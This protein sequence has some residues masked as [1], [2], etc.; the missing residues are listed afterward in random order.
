MNTLSE[1]Y[2]GNIFSQSVILLFFFSFMISTFCVIAKK[3]SFY[4]RLQSYFI[5]NFSRSFINLAFIFK[6]MNPL[7]LIL[8]YNIEYV[9]SFF[10]PYGYPNVSISL[11]GKNFLLPQNYNTVLYLYTFDTF[12][13]DML[14]IFIYG[15]WGLIIQCH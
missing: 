9:C 8:A 2:D 10:S 12:V 15:Y 11:V 7:E 6:S 3:F 1:I 5:M 4:Q 13:S 14:T